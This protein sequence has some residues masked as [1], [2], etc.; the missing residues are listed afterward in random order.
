MTQLELGPGT[1]PHPS[2]DVG[3]DPMHPMLA[4]EQ[5]AQDTPWTRHDYT[6]MGGNQLRFVDDNEFHHVFASHVLEHVPAGEDRIAVFNEAWRVLRPG[7]TFT[8]LFP[9]VGFDRH[10]L[11]ETYQPWADPTHVSYWWLPESLHYFARDIADADYGIQQWEPLGDKLN[12]M[13]A[14]RALK[15]ERDREAEPEGSWWTVRGGWEGVARLV[16]PDA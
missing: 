15:L 16:K 5:Y 4:P 9:V 8:M 3:I 10:G 14:T 13:D 7:G 12:E 1:R 11:V 6:L 2:T